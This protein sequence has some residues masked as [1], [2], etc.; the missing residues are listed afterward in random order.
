MSD[1]VFRKNIKIGEQKIPMINEMFSIVVLTILSISETR[2]YNTVHNRIES[3]KGI[4]LVYFCV[5][6]HCL[7]M[8]CQIV[9]RS[10]MI[11]KSVLD[12]SLKRR[13][14]FI[15]L[16]GGPFRYFYIAVKLNAI[17]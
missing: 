15:N 10:K 17:V 13:S 3:L 14:S 1:L 16:N 8:Q 11:V 6:V 2:P 12:D 7:I 9:W 4:L 5:F